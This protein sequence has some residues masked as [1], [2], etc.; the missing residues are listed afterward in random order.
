MGAV[1]LSLH[2][3]GLGLAAALA[4]RRKLKLTPRQEDTGVVSDQFREGTRLSREDE[5]EGLETSSELRRTP[6]APPPSDVQSSREQGGREPSRSRGVRQLVVVL[7]V[8]VAIGLG[9]YL[10]VNSL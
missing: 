3:A 8:L 10:L 7:V 2:A 5:P 9:V 6:A 1:Q 4:C